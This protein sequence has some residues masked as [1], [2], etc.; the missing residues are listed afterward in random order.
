MEGSQ[1]RLSARLAQRGRSEESPP[2]GHMGIGGI[3]KGGPAP[4]ALGRD[5][6]PKRLWTGKAGL[7]VRHP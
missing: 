3:P 6:Q 1:A 5:D 4:E 2:R 7:E